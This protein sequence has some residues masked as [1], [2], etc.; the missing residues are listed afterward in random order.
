MAMIV[1]VLVVVVVVVVWR[2]QWQQLCRLGWK[3]NTQMFHA[4]QT[5]WS[6]VEGWSAGA[7]S[8]YARAGRPKTPQKPSLTSRGWRC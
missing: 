3:K 2:R 6:A 4:V 5:H 8:S 7:P 1:L